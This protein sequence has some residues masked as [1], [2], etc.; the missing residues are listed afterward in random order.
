LSPG[1]GGTSSGVPA[2]S[3]SGC[4][5]GVSGGVI[6]GWGVGSVIGRSFLREGMSQTGTVAGGPG[7]IVDDL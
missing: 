2:G 7:S 3:I 4:G 6:S 1:W 5:E